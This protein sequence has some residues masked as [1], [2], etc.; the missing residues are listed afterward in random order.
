M[1]VTQAPAQREVT[2]TGHIQKNKAT[3]PG[4]IVT[5][6]TLHALLLAA[7]C[8]APSIRLSGTGRQRT[9]Y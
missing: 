6:L 7:G 5:V 8:A 9:R 1:L 3:D 2:M 4:A